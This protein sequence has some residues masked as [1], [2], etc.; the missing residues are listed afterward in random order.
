MSL[1]LFGSILVIADR[2]SMKGNIN[3]CIDVRLAII[4]FGVFQLE[5]YIK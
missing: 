1:A 5:I 2:K 4:V 3:K